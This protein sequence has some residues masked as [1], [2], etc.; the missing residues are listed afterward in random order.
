MQYDLIGD[1]HGQSDRLES[2]LHQLGYRVSGSSFRHPNRRA[3]FLGDLIDR[4]PQ[5]KAVIEIVRRMTD[6]DQATVVL[7][8]HEYNSILFHS[9]DP[10]S[11]TPLRDHLEKNIQ[12]HKTFLA[13]YPVGDPNTRSVIEWF[14]T[15]PVFLEYDGF[16][17]VHACW[18][19]NAIDSLG[20]SLSPQNALTEDLIVAS[21]KSANPAYRHLEHLLK[22][23]E[24]KLPD[25]V[26]LKDKSGTPRHDIRIKWWELEEPKSL[27]SLALVRT[28]L[29]DALPDHDMSHVAQPVMYG[30]DEPMVFFGHY[31][32]SPQSQKPLQTTNLV[33][34]DFS[35]HFDPPITAYRWEGN[36]FD[37]RR[38][39][40]L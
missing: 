23:L 34:L 25:G 15:M 31:S 33:C 7:G 19:Q 27:K 21:S 2:L 3:I 6:N 37:Q 13:E 28:E 30:A 8:N 38:L 11:G 39:V 14:K 22:G 1:I 40:V 9:S 36:V 26:H 17:V 24:A 32:L 12:Q 4:G 10:D 16:R 29:L 35:G 18:D 5:N 20:P